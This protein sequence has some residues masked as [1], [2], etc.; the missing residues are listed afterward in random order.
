MKM[1]I[2]ATRKQVL[3]WLA[4][5]VS[6]FTGFPNGSRV[7]AAQQASPSPSRTAC[8]VKVERARE[9]LGA[10]PHDSDLELALA[11][12]LAHCGQDMEA[13]V[14]YRQV[15][16]VKPRDVAV[17][18]EMGETQ[19]RSGETAD[20]ARAFA[21]I[22]ELDP[23]NAGAEL[24]LAHAQAILGHWDPALGLYNKILVQ[25]PE[26]YDALQGKAF[27][28]YWTRHF[29]ASQA[30][31]QKL[32][33][34]NPD[35][36]ENQNALASIAL[37]IDQSRWAA[38]RPPAGSPPQAWMGFEISYLA[39]HPGNRAALERLAR[40]EARLG[41]YNNAIR[42]DQHALR[43]TPGDAV[44]QEHMASVLAWNHQFAASIEASNELLRSDPLNRAA[45]ENLA[46]V[47]LWSGRLQEALGAEERLLALDPDNAG[48]QL[49]AAR[50]ELRLKH[51]K[52][53]RQTLTDLLHQRPENRWARIERA[54]LDINQG[55]LSGALHD[56]NAVLAL[57]FRDA[58]ASYGA[59]RI[60]YY[61][62][63]P[64][65]AY[66][67]AARVVEE[68]PKDFDAL[69]LC[70]R[71]ERARHHARH[72]R[73]LLA[74]ASRLNPSNSEIS[75]MKTRI[76]SE[77]RVTVH[78]S[79]TYA[80]EQAF[81]KDFTTPAG[82]FSPGRTVEDLNTYGSSIKTG[83]SFLPRSD[84]YVLVAS[85]PSNSPVGG[86]QGAVAPSELLYGQTTRLSKFID[87][88]GGF[89][90]VR[91]GPGAL[92]AVTSPALPV[93]MPSITPVGYAGLSLF[94]TRRLSVSFSAARRAITYTPTSVRF[95]VTETRIEAG[96]I[97]A[98]DSRTRV[99]ATFDHDIVSS[100]VY[101]QA[102]LMRGG[103][104]VL[105]RNGRDEGN[106]G[107]V[108]FDRNLIRSSRLSLD[109]GYSDLVFGYTGKR[110]GVFMGFFNPT[111]YQQHMLT[112]RASGLLWGPFRYAFTADVG[113]QQATEGAP[114]T[115][116]VEIGPAL[117]VRA[118]RSLSITAGY[119]HYNFAQS[120]G[121]VRGNA[122]QLATDWTF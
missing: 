8:M 40:A 10:S 23:G 52:A 62:G 106:T 114:F 112:S 116:A 27:I 34:L 82:Y 67:F 11:R 68:R 69:L 63:Q 107:S 85:M 76:Q 29:A 25:L 17:S 6:L 54:Q 50:L 14:W 74:R 22:L 9:A 93:A 72:A 119:F 66:P 78:T 41:V 104:V 60:Y 99:T 24:G 33:R 45:L 15:L 20:A 30:L 48:D 57:D 103:M 37:A 53:A 108:V 44:A 46:Q 105:K 111:F 3:I 18:Y 118:S 12:Q 79:S 75:E 117:T 71:I 100:P 81:S 58:D 19:A 83:F 2:R 65:R 5:A 51:G 84:S 90:G 110:R 109:A 87:L 120:L 43:V 32:R 4:F 7:L 56:Y 28:L 80:R 86:I 70:A 49:A 94:P 13:S 16:L 39:D 89:G 61:L 59:A 42:N 31:F 88:R 92:F 38:L 91:M 55:N 47:Y 113:L 77:R 96:F 64:D 122:V 26:N 36:D 21:K 101:G 115:R 35:D 98:L 97:Y 121:S 102:D 1:S 73:A 95:G